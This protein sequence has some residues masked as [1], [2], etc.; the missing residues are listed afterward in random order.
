M[1]DKPQRCIFFPFSARK[2]DEVGMDEGTIDEG[3]GRWGRWGLVKEWGLLAGS[4]AG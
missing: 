3:W 2:D 4:R 1:P